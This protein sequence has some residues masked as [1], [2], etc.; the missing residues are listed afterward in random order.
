MIACSDKTES[1]RKL[2]YSEYVT[3]IEELK[4][5]IDNTRNVLAEM[6]SKLDK[7]LEI[8]KQEVKTGNCAIGQV[9]QE[10]G[11]GTIW[12]GEAEICG[13]KVGPIV[14]T[15]YAAIL[16]ELLEKIDKL[17]KELTKWKT[18]G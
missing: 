11:E 12:V 18:P 8:N 4:L 5:E 13:I 2:T 3:T 10:V 17:E 15:S 6:T 14:T 9:V 1:N 7:L 16:E